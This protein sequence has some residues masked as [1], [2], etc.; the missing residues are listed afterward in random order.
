MGPRPGAT[1]RRRRRERRGPGRAGSGRVETLAGSATQRGRPSGQR[2]GGRGPARPPRTSCGPTGAGERARAAGTEKAP[3]GCGGESRRPGRAG[4]G[5][6]AWPL[7]GPG[8]AGGAPWALVRHDRAG[9]AARGRSRRDLGD[10]T[11]RDQPGC[12]GHRRRPEPFL[13]LSALISGQCPVPS[14]VR[15]VSRGGP[16]EWERGRAL[17]AHWP[18]TTV[19]SPVPLLAL[20][21]TEK[22]STGA[23][24]GFA[25]LHGDP[26]RS[27]C[28]PQ[29]GLFWSSPAHPCCVVK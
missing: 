4:P 14:C 20:E 18:A 5:G 23:L 28:C 13:P 26:S 29:E 6:A 11:A 16:A 8:P 24:R 17:C 19:R 2:A 27:S 1:L 7:V 10:Q 15:D 12:C 3:R 9:D 22:F 25:R 21:R